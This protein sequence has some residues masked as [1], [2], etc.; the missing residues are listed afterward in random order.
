[1]LYVIDSNKVLNPIRL[2]C[3]RHRLQFS[4]AK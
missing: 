2:E 3:R 4:I 1:M